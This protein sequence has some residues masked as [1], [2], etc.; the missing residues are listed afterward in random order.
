MDRTTERLGEWDGRCVLA[1][2]PTQRTNC[3]DDFSAARPA[4]AKRSSRQPATALLSACVAAL[5]SAD[6]SPADATVACWGD[7]TYGQC[8]VPQDLLPITSIVAGGWHTVAIRGDAAVS[9]W[10]RNDFG[11]CAVPPNLVGVFAVAG[12]TLH[13]AALLRDGTVVCWGDNCYGQCSVPAGIT[14][15]TAVSAGWFH[16]LVLRSNGTIT[17]WGSFGVTYLPA[18]LAGVTGVASGPEHAAA[19][20]RD[21][22]VVCWGNSQY[23]SGDVPSGLNDATAVAAGDNHTVALR[24]DGTVICWGRNHFGQCDPPPGL[25]GA[26]SI[27]AGG[28]HTVALRSDGTVVCWGSNQSGQCSV[29]PGLAPVSAISAGWNHTVV[30]FETDCNSN[31]VIDSLELEGHDCNN[32]GFPDS[33]DATID[34]LEDCNQNGLGDTCEKQLALELVSGEIGPIGVNSPASWTIPE[35]VLAASPVAIQVRAHGDFSGVLEYVIVNLGNQTLGSALAGTNDCGVTSWAS[36]TVSEGTFNSQITAKDRITISATAAIAVDPDGCNDGTW[37]E[38]K[39]SYTG[40]TSADCN[41]N[42]LI[43]SCEINAGLALDRNGTGVIDICENGLSNCPADFDRD[44][45]VG[46]TDLAKLLAAWGSATRVPG[47][48]LVPDG[49]IDAADL[50]AILGT[51]G[52]CVN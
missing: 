28:D 33:C 46:P 48:D 1:K 19:R 42:G 9:C 2:S 18:G 37:I 17:C 24:S 3:R 44:G 49:V 38:F 34:I 13:T 29:P 21:G 26:V 8:S 10:G 27:A 41:A 22:S 51:W 36:F 23:G 30:R 40:A 15:A 5:M 52:S 35:V 7:N 6:S 25:I 14:D 11:A 12:G 4:S 39:L 43:D 50:A 32:N 45:L 20:R 47:L 31:S 16:T